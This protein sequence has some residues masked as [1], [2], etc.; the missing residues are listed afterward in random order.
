MLNRI[1]KLSLNNRLVVLILSAMI[2]VAGCIALT[3]SEIDIFPDLNAPTVTIMTEAPGMASEEV[4]RLVT[5]PVETAVNGASGV[6]RVRSASSAGFSTVWVEFD[7]DTDPLVARQTVTEKIAP[8]AGDHPDGVA[9]PVLGPQSSILG[10][11]MI[12]GLTVKPDSLATGMS[13]TLSRLRS[14]ADREIRPRLMSLGGVSQVAVIGGDVNEYRILL[15]PKRMQNLG[16]TLAEVVEATEAINDNA[17]GGTLFDYGNEYI[18]TGN[19]NSASEQEI[20]SSVIRSD[21]NSTVLLRDIATVTQGAQEPKLG[22]ASVDTREAVL[23]TVTKQ[24][25]AGTITL[26]EKIDETLT[27]IRPQ[28]PEDVELHTHIFRQSD[29]IGRSVSNLQESL[30][31]GALMVIIVL[32]FFLMNLRTTLISVI[33]LPMSIIVTIL[34]LRFMGVTV[35]TMTLGGIAIAIGSLVDDAIVDVENV[36][37]RLRHNMELPENERRTVLKV[38]LEASKEVRMPI[39][40]SSLIIVAS[41]LPLFFLS[42][43]EGRLL[44]PLGVA[45]IVALG[46]STIVALTLTP[47]LCSYLLGSRKS[48][49]QSAREPKPAKVLK[50]LYSAAL[51]RCMGHPRV[52]IGATGALL[53][54]AVVILLLIG[55]GFLPGFNEGSMTINVTTLPGISLEESDRIGRMAEKIILETPEV[56]TVARKTGRAELDEHSLGVNMSE[57]EAPYKLSGR[58]RDEMEDDLRHRLSLIPGANIEIGQPVTHRINAMLSGSEAPVAVKIFG[59]D[60]SR[61]QSIG[62]EV[63]RIMHRINGFTDVNVE[64]P[65]GRPRITITPRR[66]IMARYG[67]TMKA[68]SEAVSVALAGKT[69]SQVYDSSLPYDVTLKYD[70]DSRN[71]I[72]ALETL[73]ID[74]NVG[75]IPLSTVAEIISTSGPDTVNRE[76]VKRRL[77]VAAAVTGRDMGGAVDELRKVIAEEVTL[78]EGYSI[79]Y[80]GQFESASSATTTLLLATLLSLAVIFMLLYGEY[81]NMGQSLLLLVNMPLAMIGGAIILPLTDQHLNIPAIIGFISLL[82]IATRNGMLLLS[83]YNTLRA[84]GYD[85]DSRIRIGSADRLLPIVMTALTSALALIPLALRGSEPGNEI[86]SPMATVIL[87][88]LLSSTVLNLF[89]VPI[90]Y[91]RLALRDESTNRFKS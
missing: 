75:K 15:D 58:S 81:R 48:I 78:P 13:T 50:K 76:N 44:R 55:R 22:A 86:Q 24:P 35:N 36:Y 29:F 68:F 43:M 8:L 87:G 42:G 85:I 90:L 32:F 72:E 2:L 17:Q 18:V 47:V 20:A 33:A 19:I 4:E 1:I 84:E 26:T 23:L 83:R 12:I 88:G 57:I 41:F 56:E 66:D 27:Q 10:E 30:L 63:G 74:S 80:G 51:G 65:S 7:W 31:E 62:E 25:K 64:R 16:V 91:R 38:V 61:M 45:F 70:T 21:G 40:N 71:T 6:R 89:I 9:A 52:M 59:T 54:V 53:I 28:L 5:F 39:F 73:P 67:I 46:A 34:I 60:L 37:K 69:V 3:R 11:M 14:I 82:G 77:T 79:S 49:R